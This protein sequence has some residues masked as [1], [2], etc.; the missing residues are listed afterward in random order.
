MSPFDSD[1]P[2]VCK[3]DIGCMLDKVLSMFKVKTISFVMQWSC[4]FNFY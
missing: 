2:A 3:K 1:R 4:P